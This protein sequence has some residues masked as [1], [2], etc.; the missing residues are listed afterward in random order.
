MI[1]LKLVTTTIAAVILLGTFLSIIYLWNYQPSTTEFDKLPATCLTTIE[2]LKSNVPKSFE[3]C[4]VREWYLQQIDLIPVTDQKL[5]G[6][7]SNLKVRAQCAFT[8]RHHTR[9]S[10]RTFM[11]SK[12]DIVTLRFRD[13]IKYG[14][15]DGPSF[16][17]L[18]SNAAAGE[19]KSTVWKGIIASAQR[20]NQQ[21][22]ESC[23]L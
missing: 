18:E 19:D 3:N 22:N 2:K 15:P 9:V 13:W 16:S 7:K 12:I 17:Q 10:A 20:T 21:V 8:I 23:D 1:K 4:K 5:S 14:Q 11:S 6:E